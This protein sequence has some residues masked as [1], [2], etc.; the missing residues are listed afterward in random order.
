LRVVVAARLHRGG[1]TRMD[2]GRPAEL[3]PQQYP[4]LV[5]KAARLQ[6]LQQRDHRPIGIPGK[7]L[8]PPDVNMVVPDVVVAEV[9]VRQPRSRRVSSET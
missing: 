6:F 3:R 7:P 1:P 8:V 2:P 9:A 4:R 5:Q